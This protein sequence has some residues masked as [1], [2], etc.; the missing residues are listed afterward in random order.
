MITITLSVKID[1][2]RRIN[3]AI[4]GELPNGWKYF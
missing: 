3:E 1:I 4:L 2:G